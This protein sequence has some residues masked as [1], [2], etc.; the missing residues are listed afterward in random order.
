MDQE[1]VFKIDFKSPEL[2]RGKTPDNI[3]IKTH[4]LC[5]DYLGGAWLKTSSD[6]IITKRISGGLTNQMYFCRLPDH[7]QPENDEP[8]E[9]VIRFYGPKHMN[10]FDLDENER[11]IDSILTVLMS[12]KNIGAKLYGIFNE[13]EILE[14]IQVN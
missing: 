8:K 3:H 4:R 6:Q 7:I 13:G 14:Y 11:T 5:C 2:M 12:E 10:N 9:V 1:K